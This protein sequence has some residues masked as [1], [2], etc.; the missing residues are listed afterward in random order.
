MLTICIFYFSVILKK[1][2]NF[3]EP[4]RLKTD[5]QESNISLNPSN[6]IYSTEPLDF[7][8]D[9]DYESTISSILPKNSKKRVRKRTHK[10]KKQEPESPVPIE[11]NVIYLAY[12]IYSTLNIIH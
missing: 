4:S 3:T 2:D 10:K 12:Y 9:N 5:T 8:S 1:N 6:S 7:K 11:K